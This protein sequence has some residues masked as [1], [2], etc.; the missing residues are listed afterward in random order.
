MAEASGDKHTAYF[1][2][3]ESKNFQDSLAGEFHGI[4]AYVDM[5]KPGVLHIISPISGTP[6]EKAGLKGGDLIKKIDDM[7]I[8]EKTTLEDAVS[9]IKGPIG[10]SVRLRI[11][12][13]TEELD[14]SIVRAKIV[15]KYVEHKRLDNADQHIKI[16]T[17]GA[18]VA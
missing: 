1:P 14:F 4:G 8:T 17:F 16:T 6:S 2:P 12:R 15:I 9:K 5:P 13:G 10:T 7:I 3:V 18:G 11:Q